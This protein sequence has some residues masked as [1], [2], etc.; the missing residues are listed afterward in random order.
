MTTRLT[1]FHVSL[2]QSEFCPPVDSSLLAALLLDLPPEPSAQDEQQIRIT[3]GAIAAQVELEQIQAQFSQEEDRLKYDG[4]TASSSGLNSLAGDVRSGTPSRSGGNS[5]DSTSLLSEVER[6]L[7]EWRINDEAWER[8]RFGSEP[9]SGSDDDHQDGDHRPTLSPANSDPAPIRS[10]DPF[11][12][13]VSMFPKVSFATIGDKL[14]SGLDLEGIMDELMTEDFIKNDHQ[15]TTPKKAAPPV[16][17]HQKRKGPKD[18]FVVSLTDVLHRAPSPNLNHRKTGAVSPV[19]PQAAAWSNAPA[20]SNHWAAT[21]SRSGHLASLTHVTT[22]RVTSLLHANGNSQA[23]ALAALLNVLRTE[24]PRPQGPDDQVEH[25][26]LLMPGLSTDRYQLLLSATE[27][28]VSDAMDLQDFIRDTEVGGGAPLARA[29]LIAEP[30]LGKS[31]QVQHQKKTGPGSA[32]YDHAARATV[33][34]TTALPTLVVGKAPSGHDYNPE[35]YSSEECRLF[36]QEYLA[37]VSH[38]FGRGPFPTP[39]LSLTHLSV[40]SATRC[41]R[42]PR[43]SSRAATTPTSAARPSPRPSAGASS[44]CA[45]APGRPAPRAPSSASGACTTRARSTCTTSPCTTRSARCATRA[46][47]GGARARRARRRCRCGS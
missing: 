13:L 33:A 2:T 42:P 26:K 29:E 28:D 14:A 23:R 5:T 9:S 7:E 25:L 36:A 3:L 6:T 12:F 46:T 40:R 15:E 8:S 4:S 38:R 16:K 10:E 45:S 19:S 22:A 11:D 34:G 27:G 20:S 1:L 43:A 35:A 24:R 17:K 41:T 18:A 32:L 31:V 39:A 37:K 47:R 44:T 30:Q 21:D